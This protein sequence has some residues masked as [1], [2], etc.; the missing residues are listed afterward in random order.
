MDFEEGKRSHPRR[1]AVR[2][3]TP[4]DSGHIPRSDIPS[5]VSADDVA[6]LGM[7][8]LRGPFINRMEAVVEKRKEWLYGTL[9]D[10]VDV[11]D[12]AEV[13]HAPE[14]HCHHSNLVLQLH[15]WP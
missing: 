7:E 8:V 4:L 3:V 15:L 13:R 12:P 11:G 1:S 5:K 14:R 10:P 6:L 2:R 9:P